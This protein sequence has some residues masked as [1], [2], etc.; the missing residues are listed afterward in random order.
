MSFELLLVSTDGSC[1]FGFASF[2]TCFN[3]G[4]EII[5]ALL[6]SGNPGSELG[7]AIKDLSSKLSLVFG[8]QFFRLCLES[9]ALSVDLNDVIVTDDATA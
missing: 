3:L 9:G 8:D 7:N 2:E 4:N 1:T 5:N 6:V